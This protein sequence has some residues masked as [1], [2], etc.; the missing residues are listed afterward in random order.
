[1]TK[2]CK[3]CH[4]LY[5]IIPSQINRSK[6]CSKECML[7]DKSSAKHSYKCDYCGKEILIS[8]TE[9]QKLKQGKLKHKFCNR[10]CANSFMNNKKEKVCLNC[11]Q[12]FLIGNAFAEV[13]KFCCPECYVEYKNKNTKKITRCCKFCNK[14]FST[15]HKT[16]IFCNRTCASQYKS[17]QHSVKCTCDY[18]QK[19]FSMV[20]NQYNH[21][22]NHYCSKECKYKAILQNKVSK[23]QIIINEVL[24]ELQINFINEEVFFFFYVDNYLN[25]NNLIIENMGKYWHCTPW[26]NKD[27]NETQYENIRRDKAKRTFIKNQFDIDILYLWEDD[28]NNN[29]ELCKQLIL[30]YIN[31]HGKIPNYN[32]FNYCLV[33][34]KIQLKEELLYPYQEQELN[35]YKHLYK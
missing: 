15:Y 18:C 11:G 2:E 5:K 28:I 33:N 24:S 7:S 22:I 32:S 4:K 35:N 13:Q 34:D 10:E 16:K 31:N 21:N 30:L 19:E 1:M 17:Q 8:E 29:I 9:Y 12:T 20:I 14:E 6:Y 26:D 3:Y 27:I 23:I 25:E